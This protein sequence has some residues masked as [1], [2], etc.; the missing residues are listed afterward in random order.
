VRVPDDIEEAIR[1]AEAVG[2]PEL[3]AY[4]IELRTAVYQRRQPM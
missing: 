2:M 3:G 4:A 1:Q